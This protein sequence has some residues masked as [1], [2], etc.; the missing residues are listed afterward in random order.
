[1]GLFEPARLLRKR[2]C[3]TCPDESSSPPPPPQE[4]N[5][6]P[7]QKRLPIKTS[8][9]QCAA[10][11]IDPMR[12]PHLRI[13]CADPTED[14]CPGRITVCVLASSRTRLSN[15]SCHCTDTA[16][17]AFPQTN[18]TAT[19]AHTMDQSYLLIRPGPG[20]NPPIYPPFLAPGRRGLPE[21]RIPKDHL[22]FSYP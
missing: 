13:N 3:S 5:P 17:V 7:T 12:S 20:V 6:Q 4:K 14:S 22:F 11:G 10:P 2:L 21:D 1:M 8:P 19:R 15:L 18:A 9:H 16:S